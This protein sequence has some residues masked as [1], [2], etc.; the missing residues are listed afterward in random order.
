M[1]ENISKN[2]LKKYC[3][4]KCSNE[5]I[6]LVE[7]WYIALSRQRED[8]P[9]KLD[10]LLHTKKLLDEAVSEKIYFRTKNN[11]I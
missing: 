7:S 4:D 2:L 9:V 8:I 10:D 3:E 6:V 1:K 11:K 5:E